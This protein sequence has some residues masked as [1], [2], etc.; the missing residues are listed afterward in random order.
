M[1]DSLVRITREIR[2]STAEIELGLMLQLDFSDIG[3]IHVA[4]DAVTNDDAPADCT[5]S[6]DLSS[7]GMIYS[8]KR[9]PTY[10]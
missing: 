9:D 5:L 8:G 7:F 10:A 3:L 1:D 4:S 2:R 6:I